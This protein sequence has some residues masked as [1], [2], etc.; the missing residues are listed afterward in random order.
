MGKGI[1]RGM[2]G[3]GEVWEGTKGMADGHGNEW[4]C[5]ADRVGK[6]NTSPGRDSLGMKEAPKSEL[7]SQFNQQTCCP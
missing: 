5:A 3:M 1:G 6:Q 7:F 2:R 4:R